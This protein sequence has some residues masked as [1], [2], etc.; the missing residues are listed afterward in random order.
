MASS[1]RG[2]VYWATLAFGGVFL[3]GTMGGEIVYYKYFR[4]DRDEQIRREREDDEKLKKFSKLELTTGAAA[5]GED[6][7]G[8]TSAE[9]EET[10]KNIKAAQEGR[11]A[12]FKSRE[13]YK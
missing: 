6:E 8:K 2:A 10:I 11:S 5:N 13:E 3:G 1:R 4:K 12:W 7:E 9:V